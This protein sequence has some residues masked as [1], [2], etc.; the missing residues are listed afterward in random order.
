MKS[1]LPTRNGISPSYLWLPEGN[2]ATILDFLAERFPH[3]DRDTWEY[4]LQ[5]DGI[6]NEQGVLYRPDTPY[7][8]GERMF[9]YRH[10][11]K[12]TKIPFQETILFQNDHFIVVDK[13][14]FLPVAP[15]GKYLHETLLVRLKKRFN[16]DFITP[17]HRID[18]E[19]AGVI[20]F[21]KNPETRG[22]YQV[23]FQ[24]RKMHKTYQAIAPRLPHI[25]FPY[26]HESRMVKST[27]FF[28]MKEVDGEPNSKTYIDCIETRGDLARYHLE[29]VSGK[30]HQLRV[31]LASLGAA[32][33]NDSFY[34]EVLPEK[35]EEDFKN[36]LQLLAK[37]I[38]FVDPIIGQDCYFESQ[39]KL[40]FPVGEKTD[41]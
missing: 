19:T 1:P 27:P 41:G 29:P 24:E 21:S 36:P 15:A 23:M 10:L 8:G 3:I 14:H 32:I 20:L 18:R 37:S 13:P 28:C 12:E 39:R 11:E 4:R 6:M 31:H 17:M 40:D 22:L 33:L 34:P 35:E 9:Y 38:A 26:T 2:W 16:M 7:V 30:Q 25:D 5:Q